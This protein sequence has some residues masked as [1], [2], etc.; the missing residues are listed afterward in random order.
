MRI[1][2]YGNRRRDTLPYPVYVTNNKHR[3]PGVRDSGPVKQRNV[4]YSPM[5]RITTTMKDRDAR[6]YQLLERAFGPRAFCKL[7]GAPADKKNGKCSA[8]TFKMEFEFDEVIANLIRKGKL[9]RGGPCPF[10]L[11]AAALANALDYGLEAQLK[12]QDHERF[13][14]SELQRALKHIAG[15][16]NKLGREEIAIHHADDPFYAKLMDVSIAEVFLTGA[17]KALKARATAVVQQRGRPAKLDAQDITRCCLEVWELLMRKEPGKNNA[18]F[19]EL[20]SAAWRT[21]YGEEQRP[22][23]SWAYHIDSLKQQA[24]EKGQTI[25]AGF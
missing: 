25:V 23:P 17:L 20:L 19:L 18:G 15:A 12:S 8:C 4:S 21:V 6:Y 22:E 3:S 5:G 13:A 2:E 24:K 16:L 7:S 14:I 1:G 9:R 10:F 11:I